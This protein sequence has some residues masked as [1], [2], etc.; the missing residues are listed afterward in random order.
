[1]LDSRDFDLEGKGS[2]RLLLL[3]QR[4]GA[5]DYISGPRAKSYLDAELYARNGVRVHWKDYN[6]YPEYPQLHG[7]YAPDLSIIDLL[8]NC[9]ERAA[10]FTKPMRETRDA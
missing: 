5:T 7:A 3:L 8:M 2:D 4:L 1:M 6:H 10:D 9:G